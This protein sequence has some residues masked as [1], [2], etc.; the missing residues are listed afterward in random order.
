MLNVFG[1]FY[2]PPE[3]IPELH[4]MH[5]DVDVSGWGAVTSENYDVSPKTFST[6]NSLIHVCPGLLPK[7]IK[8]KYFT[9]IHALKTKIFKNNLQ[10]FLSHFRKVPIDILHHAM[11]Q[12]SIQ[13]PMNRWLKFYVN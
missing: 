4:H 8:Y 13:K 10:C 9:D 1:D 3:F 5:S 7:Y 12:G 6:N 11:Q 2:F